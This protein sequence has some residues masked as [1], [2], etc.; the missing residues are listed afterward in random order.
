MGKEKSGK[1]NGRGGALLSFSMERRAGVSWG[2]NVDRDRLP[3]A[4]E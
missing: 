4:R 1:A 2:S 3:E